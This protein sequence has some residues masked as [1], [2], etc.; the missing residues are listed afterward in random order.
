MKY[1]EAL[2]VS[3][4]NEVISSLYQHN[5]SKIDEYLAY[6]FSTAEN[7]KYMLLNNKLEGFE[8]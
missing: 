6:L 7:I 3:E 5:K 1:I 2:S 8:L 4:K